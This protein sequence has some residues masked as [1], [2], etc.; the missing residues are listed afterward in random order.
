MGGR[1]AAEDLWCEPGFAVVRGA[2]TDAHRTA[3]REFR[4]QGVFLL[5]SDR[6]ASAELS[7]TERELSRR[8]DP[9]STALVIV[10]VMLV[11]AL[12]SVLPW[13]GR[14]TGWEI[15]LG[16]AD[17]GLNIGLLP[18]LFSI[19]STIAGILLSTLALTTR[20]WPLSWAAAMGCGMVSLEGLLAI[21]SR[22]TNAVAGPSFGLVLAVISMFVIASQWLRIAWSRP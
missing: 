8:F 13:V 11:L 9:G 14:A 16:Q 2:R 5:T 17:P 4:E 6:E 1:G 15:L 18:R 7:R 19:N 22:Q 21:W 3:G 20:W 12:C 10:G